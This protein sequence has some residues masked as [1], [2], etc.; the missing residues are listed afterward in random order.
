MRTDRSNAHVRRTAARGLARIAALAAV[1]C[2]CGAP[3]IPAVN[4]GSTQTGPALGLWYDD[5]GDGAVEVR[6]C[7]DKLC[8]YIVWLKEPVSTKTGKPKVDAYNP[9]PSKRTRSICGLQ[10]LGNL[11]RQSDG[12]WDNGWVYDPKEGKSYDAAV[13][14]E[15]RSKLLMTGYKGIKLLSKTLTW[16]RAP[17]ELPRC[18]DGV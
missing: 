6:P 10:V 13:A 7:G 4:A 1:A 15:G 11:E 17:A 8:G 14:L 12:G 9:E 3:F 16:T 2:A 18:Q 5:T